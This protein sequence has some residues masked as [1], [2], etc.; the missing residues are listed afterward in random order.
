MESLNKHIPGGCHKNIFLVLA[1]VLIA[2]FAILTVSGA[3]DISNKIKQGKYIGQEIET[4]NTIS[5]S[6]KGEIYTQPD[7]SIVVFSVKTEKTTVA[8]AMEENVEK[9]NDIIEAMKNLGVEEKDL[10]TIN[11]NI[12]PR[13]EY[14]DYNVYPSTGRRV[15]V[16]YEVT[17]SLQVKIRDLTKIGQIIQEAAD[18]GSNQLG[19]LQFTV[20]EQDEFKSQARE[21]AIKQAKEKA[22]EIASQLGVDLV[23]ITGFSE[24]SQFP[25][26]E[27]RNL[28]AEDIG[29]GGAGA[30]QIETGQNKIEVNVTLTYEIN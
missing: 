26:Y 15:L 1:V 6:G 14:R 27:Y 13:Y 28:A 10:K 11:F 23:R 4:K 22:E 17:Q 16:G 21:E 24:S 3:V 12:S 20:D 5:V 8:K 19:N 2:L 30:P 9:M 18:L 7:L 29:I 25:Y